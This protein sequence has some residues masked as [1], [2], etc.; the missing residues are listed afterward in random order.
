M[1]EPAGS[2]LRDAR[3][4]AGLSQSELGRRAGVARSVISAY[5]AGARQPALPTLAKLIRAAGFELD[6][7]LRPARHGRFSGP[8]GGRLSINSPGQSAGDRRPW[9]D[10]CAGVRQRAPR[11]GQT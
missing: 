8:I 4:R 5:E 11:R 3:G 6:L 10:E 9:A 2:L 1:D 7:K